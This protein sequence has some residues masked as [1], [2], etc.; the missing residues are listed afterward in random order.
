MRA[1]YCIYWPEQVNNS[2]F[3]SLN[4]H[5]SHT[6]MLRNHDQGFTNYAGLHIQTMLWITDTLTWPE[7]VL[8]QSHHVTNKNIPLGKRGQKKTKG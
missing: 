8:A 2:E 6:G 7:I 3:K 1:K 5:S 4:A